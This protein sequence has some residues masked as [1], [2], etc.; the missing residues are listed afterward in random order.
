[1]KD[2]TPQ[3]EI[4][5]ACPN[6]NAEV[7]LS[8]AVARRVREQ[9]QADFDFRRKQQEKLFAQRDKEL[10]DRQER[11]ETAQKT[12]DREVKARLEAGK[13]KLLETARRE[14]E[15][16]FMLKVNH[17]QTQLDANKDKVKQA[18]SRE[19]E[20]L[21]KQ[22]E[23]KEK[24]E[25]L[26]LELHRKLSEERVKIREAAKDELAEGH[27]LKIAEKDKVIE[28]CKK[29][30]AILL[31]KA[32]QGSQQLQGEV[33]E[34]E[35]EAVLKAQFPHDEILPTPTG[36]RGA[37]LLQ[38][39]RT[40]S[41]TECGTII[42]ESKRTRNW[43]DGWI[44]KLKENQRTNGADIAVI[45]TRALPKDVKSFAWL[46]GVWVTDLAAYIG[47]AIALRQGLVS[48]AH[49][50]QS[51]IGKNEKIEVLYRYL[52]GIEFRQKIETFVEAF[53]GLRDELESERRA[54]A[55][56][57]ASREKQITKAIDSA[58]RMY[59]DIQ[60]IIGQ[61]AL[62]EIKALQLGG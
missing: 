2:N 42:W 14:A 39:I 23:L 31:Q 37:D 30:I 16:E 24:Q 26:E 21:R 52:S 7:P 44:G 47:L 53:I 60:G 43:S 56:I 19:L 9:V 49:E 4:I 28:D 29:Q 35:L 18:Q 40:V 33:L 45:L 11:L 48:T 41:G 10:R 34:L 32:D 54:M 1:M 62:P 15:G 3:S 13:A 51:A 20:L 46:E 59:G 50:R 22:T 55:K 58:A 25:A 27:K 8:E 5:I 6:C 38:K 57:W 17:L 36:V 61:K 12:L